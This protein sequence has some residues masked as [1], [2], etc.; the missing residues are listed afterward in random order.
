MKLLQ[1]SRRSF[2]KGL[3]LGA[4]ATFLPALR[5]GTSYAAGNIPTRL[6]VYWAGHGVPRHVYNFKSAGGGAPTE[7]DFVFPEIRSPLNA[8]KK[9][10]IVLSGMD[11]VSATVDRTSP[12]NAHYEGETH[13]LAAI[14]RKNGDT[15]GGPSID[16]YIAKAINS[17]AP[18][19]K[20]QSLSLALQVDGN[21]SSTKV[22]TQGAGQVI[23][24]EPNPAAVYKRI[25]AG[26]KPPTTAP[27]QPAGPSAAE[28]A[29]MQQKS[30]LDFVLTDFDA[31]KPTLS[32]EHQTKLQA[33]QDAVRDLER[34]LS[35]GA[36]GTFTPGAA[37]ADPTANVTVGARNAYPG[38]STILKAN[39]ASMSKLVQSAFACDLTRVAL[40][41]LADPFGDLIGYQS[42]SNGTTDA[43]DL[44]HKT[45]YNNA[46][47][48]KANPSAMATVAKWHQ[49]E[50]Q[51]FAN[52]LE[53]LR[54]VPEADGSTMLDHTVVL[55]CG[56]IG[57]HGHELTALPWVVGGGSAVGFKGGRYMQ[58]T[59]AP[60]NNL[61]VSIAQ[62]MGVQ[63]QT[64]GNAAVCTGPLAGLRV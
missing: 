63:T 16:Q 43:H 64:F 40:M 21:T 54:Q 10:L 2:A 31:V 29:A 7:T 39:I 53:L 61:F 8:I 26:F 36:G 11:M 51:Q 17:P 34:S 62:A 28:V 46:G 49:W 38:T 4:A 23:P 19:T 35:L 24:L 20:F 27:Q 45:S 25:F 60:H 3:G 1:P 6:I 15:A 14:N 41:C 32:K 55:L 18:V 37:C 59:K 42:G 12:S 56:Q 57:E 5:G 48:L 33:H 50:A 44:V 9:D 47:T 13:C 58:Y 22:C 52:M 30:V